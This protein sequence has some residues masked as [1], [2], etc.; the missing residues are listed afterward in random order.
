LQ[1]LEVTVSLVDEGWT[2]A[3]IGAAPL[4]DAVRKAAEAMAGTYRTLEDP[5]HLELSASQLPPRPSG[6]VI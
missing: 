2:V 1:A 4:A 6:P 5:D 3:T